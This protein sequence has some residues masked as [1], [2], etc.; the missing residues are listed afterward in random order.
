MKNTENNIIT[1]PP[2]KEDTSYYDVIEKKIKELFKKELYFPLLSIIN[3]KE[4]TITNA[5]PTALEDA[6]RFDKVHF[7]NGTFSG[8]FNASISKELRGYG[9]AWDRKTQTYKINLKY[10]PFNI[11]NIISSSRA[12]FDDKLRI[13]DDKLSK[14][15]TDEFV[16]KLHISDAFDK[17]LWKVEK[18]FQKSVENITVSPQLSEEQRK[19]IAYEWQG[20][21]RLWIKGWT[22]EQVVES[23]KQS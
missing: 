5:K 18:D 16:D 6:I 19:R 15:N 7:W 1:L 10:L 9:A 13:I 14:V 4:K 22:E 21:M 3:I 11:R 2:I 17:T 8:K 20:N 23:Q 12:K